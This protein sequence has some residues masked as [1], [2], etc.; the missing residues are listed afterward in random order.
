MSVIHHTPLLGLRV[1]LRVAEREGVGERDLVREDVE[2][3]EGT[4][5]SWYGGRATPR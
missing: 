1:L 4:E 2:E 3:R 5:A